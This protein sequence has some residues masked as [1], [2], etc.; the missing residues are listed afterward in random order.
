MCEEGLRG[1]VTNYVIISTFTDF[2]RGLQQAVS[3]ETGS[4]GT[5]P[6]NLVMLCTFF[7]IYVP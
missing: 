3:L 1:F 5:S 6:D 2:C 4:D 7:C